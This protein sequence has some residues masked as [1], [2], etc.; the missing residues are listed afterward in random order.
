MVEGSVE[1]DLDAFGEEDYSSLDDN[2]E[3]LGLVDD[4]LDELKEAT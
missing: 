2:Q 1:T 4:E 3:D